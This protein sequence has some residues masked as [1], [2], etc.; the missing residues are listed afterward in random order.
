MPFVRALAQAGLRCDVFLAGRLG[1]GFVEPALGS[2]FDATLT[3]MRRFTPWWR[4]DVVAA[5]R[6]AQPRAI[7]LEHGASLDFTWTLLATHRMP[8][9][10]RILWTHGIE[11]S[12][13]H[14]RRRSLA[15]IGR[16]FQLAL[17]DAILCYSRSIAQ[18]VQDR[19]PTKIVG[20]APNST[21]GTPLLAARRRLAAKGRPALRAE[22]SLP[23]RFYIAGLGRLVPEKEFHRLIPILGLVK[24]AGHDVGLILVGGGPELPRIRELATSA[25]Y[26]ERTDVVFTGPVSDPAALAQWLYC[27]DVCVNP[28]YLGLSVVDCLYSGLPV[29]SCAPGPRGPY[30][31]PEWE[32]LQAGLTGWLAD[33]NSDEEM[34]ELTSQYLSMTAEERRGHEDACVRFA[35]TTLGVTPMV[36]GLLDVLAALGQTP[37]R[38]DA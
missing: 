18:R 16:W 15:S 20:V 26:V 9:V 25:G 13:L 19:F 2:A 27:A 3:P 7:L 23:H 1:R 31:S 21:D 29:V 36:N 32:Y 6:K 34:A 37:G 14:S 33:S 30:H 8:G 17:A 5:V 24:R 10:P 28:G 22:L 38:V 12:E 11:R 35:E 4:G